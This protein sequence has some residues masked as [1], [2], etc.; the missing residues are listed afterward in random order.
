ML[1][2]G[3]ANG[4]PFKT[5]L[6]SRDVWVKRLR[7]KGQVI[8]VGFDT[9]EGLPGPRSQDTTVGYRKG[10]FP[11][12]M[13]DVQ[14]YL[15]SRFKDFLLVKGLFSD[16]LKANRQLLQDFPPVFVAIDCDYYSS[17]M[18]VLEELLPDLAPHGCLFYFDD[19]QIT[20]WS[21]KTGELRAIAEV[22]AGKFGDHIQLVEYPL[23]I[24]TREMRHYKQVYH[25]VNL[26]T[27]DQQLRSEPSRAPGQVLRDKRIS[28]L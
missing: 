3:V 27:L 24:E 18:E 16:T 28:P 14:Q 6:H 2:F 10:D 20:F 11:S 5:L 25:L 15:E 22:N 19:T 26:E 21:D 8:G 13:Q 23:W 1:E 9:F 4:N 12:D 7:A 17:T